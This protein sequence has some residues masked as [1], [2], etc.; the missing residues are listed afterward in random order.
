MKSTTDLKAILSIGEL[1]HHAAN[2]VFDGRTNLRQGLDTLEEAL[3]KGQL[4]SLVAFPS[5]GYAR[6]RKY[7]ITAAL[8]R[9]RTLRC[10]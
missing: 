9:L 6:P 7:E 1:L 10:I 4:G 3:E 5:G 8:N 2:H